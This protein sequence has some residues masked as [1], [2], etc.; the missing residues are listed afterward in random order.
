MWHLV[1]E[2]TNQI[3]NNGLRGTLTHGQRDG[4]RG[5][6]LGNQ[7]KVVGG[8][9]PSLARGDEGILAEVLGGGP[10]GRILLEAPVEESAEGV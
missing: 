10:F 1:R 3:R 9:T 7:M 4:G 6:L 2:A 5:S 8:D